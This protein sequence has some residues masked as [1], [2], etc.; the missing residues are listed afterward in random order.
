MSNEL[1]GADSLSVA[2]PLLHS[3]ES[4]CGRLNTGSPISQIPTSRMGRTV[5]AKKSAL[6]AF[7]DKKFSD[8]PSAA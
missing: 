4:G 3:W 2:K 8:D 5:I 1:S 6:Q 7:I